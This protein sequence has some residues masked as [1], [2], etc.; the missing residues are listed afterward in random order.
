M[1]AFRVVAILMLLTNA[2]S[3]AAEGAKLY[4]FIQSS[5]EQRTLT[6]WH[7]T[8][9]HCLS[10]VL[11]AIAR[12]AEG[13]NL[14]VPNVRLLSESRTLKIGDPFVTATFL[15]GA[16]GE[17]GD[18]LELVRFANKKFLRRGWSLSFI[19]DREKVAQDFSDRSL[20]IKVYSHA[21]LENVKQNLL[22]DP[23]PELYGPG[24]LSGTIGM[25][26]ATTTRAEIESMNPTQLLSSSDKIIPMERTLNVALPRYYDSQG[27]SAIVELRTFSKDEKSVDDVRKVL[28]SKGI[29]MTLAAIRNYPGLYDQ[30]IIYTYGDKASVRLYRALGFHIDEKVTPLSTPIEHEGS[31]WWCLAITPRE[32][33]KNI[34]KLEGP[35]SVFGLNQPHPIVMPNG[36]T[37]LAAPRTY[38]DIQADGK[39]TVFTVNEDTEISPGLKAASGSEVQFKRGKISAIERLAAPFGV[40]PAG[41]SVGFDTKDAGPLPN[42]SHAYTFGKPLLLERYPFV[43]RGHVTFGPTEKEIVGILGED[44][45]LEPG[46]VAKHAKRFGFRPGNKGG[47]KAFLPTEFVLAKPYTLPGNPPKTIPAGRRMRVEYHEDGTRIIQ[48]YYK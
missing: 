19:K 4:R 46:L 40:L 39:S 13:S 2:P 29:A 12:G 14:A 10:N 42:P 7:D 5:E 23:R 37:A 9:D 43:L 3:W 44:L 47:T 45:E 31:K 24:V 28:V 36:R 16:T 17:L 33:E 41:S 15:D 6:D 18:Q 32:L 22:Q 8:N 38:F 27:R 11:S 30:P 20:Y 48:E 21:M 25:T 34:L 26:Y 35:R 1:S